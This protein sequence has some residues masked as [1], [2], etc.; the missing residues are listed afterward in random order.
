MIEALTDIQWI[1]ISIAALSIGMS[2]TGV[3][4]MMLMIIQE[5]RKL[6]F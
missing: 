2:K 4:G 1:A 3:P 5:F 6:H